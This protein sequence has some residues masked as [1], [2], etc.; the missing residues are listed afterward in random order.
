MVKSRDSEALKTSEGVVGKR[1]SSGHSTIKLPL[2][3][4]CGRTLSIKQ[5]VEIEEFTDRYE[6]IFSEEWEKG[7]KEKVT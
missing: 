3:Q 7:T 6:L 4:K 1:K 2:K 5:R